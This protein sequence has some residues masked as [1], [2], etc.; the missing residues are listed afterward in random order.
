ML[1]GTKKG[2]APSLRQAKH[3]DWGETFYTNT[4]QSYLGLQNPAKGSHLC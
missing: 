3:K 2:I 4:G 1:S